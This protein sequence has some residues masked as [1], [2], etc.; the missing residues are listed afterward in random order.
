LNRV[1]NYFNKCVIFIIKYIFRS[2][3][4]FLSHLHDLIFKWWMRPSTFFNRTNMHVLRR[5]NILIFCLEWT[6]LEYK[7]ENR[8]TVR[9]NSTP[10]SMRFIC[11]HLTEIRPN[12]T[13]GFILDII[14]ISRGGTTR[15]CRVQNLTCCSTGSR[16]QYIVIWWGWQYR[17]FSVLL[18]RL[19]RSWMI[20][21]ESLSV[22]YW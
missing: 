16:H 2:F 1:R 13:T 6:I 11:W 4:V 8:I 7:Y 20:N 15:W 21:G 12:I 17:I 22:N 9:L 14:P 18:S 3:I 19:L 10:F 5:L